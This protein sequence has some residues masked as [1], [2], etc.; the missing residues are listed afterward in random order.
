MTET[1]VSR[2]IRHP[3]SPFKRRALFSI[4]ILAL[5]MAI[6]T[7]GMMFLEGWDSVTSFYFMAL[8]ATAEGRALSPLTVAGK[9]FASLMAF[10]AIGAAISTI[11]FTF[12]PLLGSVVKESFAY[13]EIEED[14]LK[15]KLERKDQAHSPINQED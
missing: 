9:L 14:R 8:L 5:V 1:G 2:I 3:L 12:G 15:A 7:I 4:A 6:G 11:T 10:V 13:V